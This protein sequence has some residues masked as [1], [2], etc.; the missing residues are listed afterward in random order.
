M[1]RRCESRRSSGSNPQ[2]FAPKA[3]HWPLNHGTP[4]EE[5]HSSSKRLE[6]HIPQLFSVLYS[7]KWALTLSPITVTRLLSFHPLSAIWRMYSS[8]KWSSQWSYDGHIRHGHRGV[9]GQGPRV[10]CERFSENKVHAAQS[11]AGR[12][13]PLRPAGGLGGRCKPLKR[14]LG[15]RPEKFWKSWKFD[16]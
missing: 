8:S 14:G 7:G 2:P 13:A 12:E 4:H 6:E 16:A 3:L 15:Q 5:E 9:A 1:G 10:V 11:A